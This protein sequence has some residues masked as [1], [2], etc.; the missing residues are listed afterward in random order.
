M[1]SIM[2]ATC[3]T[4]KSLW[5]PFFTLKDK[6]IDKNIPTYFCTDILNEKDLDGVNRDG[7]HLLTYGKPSNMSFDG[8]FYDRS[9]DHL[10]KINTK[11]I[12]YFV[13]DMFPLAPVS[14]ET[15]RDLMDS[16]DENE[17][18]KIIKLS[19]HSWPFSGS[20]VQYKGRSFVQA[21]NESDHY[22]MNVQP[23]LI[24]KD[25]FIDMLKYCKVHNTSMHQNG[26]LEIYGTEFIRNTQFICLRV[27]QDIVKINSAGGVVQSGFISD[28]TKDLLLKEGIVVKTYG[29][30]LIFILTPE[31]YALAGS[32]LRDEFARR[33][34]KPQNTA[35]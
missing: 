3:S 23:I 14:T 13:D 19:T 22:I 29:N 17:S 15:L 21:K 25:F 26:G 30:N 1:L 5:A 16:M 7:L 18:I 33:G 20:K 24:R 32:A 31:E 12:L 11:Y 27:C 8:N 35:E 34:V 9:L 2:Y 6:Y 4:Y 10:S 28:K